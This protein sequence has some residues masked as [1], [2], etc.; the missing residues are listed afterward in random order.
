MTEFVQLDA[1]DRLLLEETDNLPITVCL[2]LSEVI[3][4]IK[5]NKEQSAKDLV[6]WQ[7]QCA[8]AWA[9]AR[10]RSKTPHP[11]AHAH[12]LM[13]THARTHAHMRQL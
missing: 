11:H 7:V 2:I 6:W 1:Q 12:A 5:L 4:E 9:R 13:L 8:C 10:T 3:N